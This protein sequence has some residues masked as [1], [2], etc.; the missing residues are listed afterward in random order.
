MVCPGARVYGHYFDGETADPKKLN[1]LARDSQDSAL[2]SDITQ[3]PPMHEKATTDRPRATNV[4][5]CLCAMAARIKWPIR[6]VTVR[7]GSPSADL[8][9]SPGN[10][11]KKTR[12]SPL[13]SILGLAHS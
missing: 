9:S 8:P 3:H 7:W 1:S 6:D 4:P 10:N 11:T 12:P 5:V 13:Q 2:Y